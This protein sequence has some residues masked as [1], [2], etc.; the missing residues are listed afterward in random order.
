MLTISRK[1]RYFSQVE[2]KFSQNADEI[3]S[4]IYDFFQ[5]LSKSNPELRKFAKVLK[6]YEESCRR[7]HFSEDTYLSHPISLTP[8]HPP[9]HHKFCSADAL[10]GLLKAVVHGPPADCGLRVT[11]HDAAVVEPEP[12][13]LAKS[14][15]TGGWCQ[16]KQASSF[17]E[18]LPMCIK[19]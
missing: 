5:K 3:L 11:A 17:T 8:N 6:I 9:P 13:L 14:T 1:I 2:M 18:K 7:R 10:D 4:E 15:P 12:D 16:M 19:I